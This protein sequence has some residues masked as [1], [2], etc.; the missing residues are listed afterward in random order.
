M[1]R[2]KNHL[3]ITLSNVKS[4]LSRCPLD[5]LNGFQGCLLAT[6]AVVTDPAGLGCP[7]DIPEELLADTLPLSWWLVL[8]GFFNKNRKK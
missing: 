4:L 3:R 1:M 7:E 6:C 8:T 5:F 2:Y